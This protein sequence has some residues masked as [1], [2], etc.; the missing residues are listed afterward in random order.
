[1]K[2]S[3]SLMTTL[4]R[5]PFFAPDGVETGGAAP[6]ADAPPAAPE[7]PADPGGDELSLLGGE[8]PPSDKDTSPA[9]EE[10]ADAPKDGEKPPEAKPEGEEGKEGEQAKPEDKSGETLVIADIRVPEGFEALDADA[11]AALEPVARELGLDTAQTQQMVD[12]AAK[13][14]PGMLERAQAAQTQALVDEMATTRKGWLETSQRDK[15]FGGNP[16]TLAKNVAIARTFRDRFFGPEAVEVL[17]A[18]GLGDHPELV[19]GFV[20]AGLAFQEDGFITTGTSRGGDKTPGQVFYGEEF[21]P[22]G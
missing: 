18:S 20:R 17:N 5:L 15:E 7:T 14:L 3:L 21:Q 22:K 10:G 13:V 12:V 19:R 1:M 16:E 9:A 6:A 4:S 8:A 2:T 11:L